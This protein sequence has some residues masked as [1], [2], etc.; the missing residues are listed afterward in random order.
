MPELPEVETIRTQLQKEIVGKTI[1]KITGNAPKMVRGNIHDAIGKKVEDIERRAKILIWHLSGD[2]DILFHLK[3]TG[4]L[5]YVD[6]SGQ[7]FGGGHPVPPL[8]RPSPNASTR[9]TIEFSDEAHL[10]FNDIRKF[11]WMIIGGAQKLSQS[12]ELMQLGIEPLTKEFTAN[13][14][15]ALL[16]K[17]KT[18]I[19]Q[20]LMDQSIIAGI[21]NLYSDEILWLSKISPIRL[22]N[23]IE[24]AEI[25]LLHRAIQQVLKKGIEAGGASDSVYVDI[26]GRQGNFM[27]FAHAYHVKQCSR[28]GGQIKRQK[29]SGRTAHWCPKC[30]K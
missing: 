11:G 5:I 29:F 15:A 27:K 26:L 21:G 1:K 22:A 10:Y 9:I 7:K 30:Q 25:G 19:K 23:Q 17:K 3:L 18:R 16:T 20:V 6:K 28:C 12:K 24:P 8:N 4:Q 13:V 2:T 14:L